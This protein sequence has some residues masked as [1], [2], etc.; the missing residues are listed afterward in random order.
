[1]GTVVKLDIDVQEPHLVRLH[2]ALNLS[3][4]QSDSFGLF[5]WI[6]PGL[7]IL[8]ALTCVLSS[9]TERVRFLWRGH[10]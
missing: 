8:S 10:S 3:L 2:T 6:D 7:L 5:W 9:L 1:M 4:G